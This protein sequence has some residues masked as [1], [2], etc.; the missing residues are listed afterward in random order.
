M[1]TVGAGMAGGLKSRLML[2][3]SGVNQGWSTGGDGNADPSEPTTGQPFRLTVRSRDASGNMVYSGGSKISVSVV[4]PPVEPGS[5]HDHILA[6]KLEWE[7]IDADNGNYFV[8]LTT[9]RP[10]AHSVTVKMDGEEVIGS[11]LALNAVAP[12]VMAVSMSVGKSRGETLFVCASAIANAAIKWALGEWVDVSVR[13]DAHSTPP[14][15]PR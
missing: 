9:V 14:S 8:D 11:P 5:E 2:R 15:T 6:P 3:A 10:G 7:V 13:A 12:K 4:E 1:R